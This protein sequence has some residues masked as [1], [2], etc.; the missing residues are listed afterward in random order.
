MLRE[1]SW[2]FWKVQTILRL[3]MWKILRK[4]PGKVEE[5]SRK[6]KI[7]WGKSRKNQDF[8]EKSLQIFWKIYFWK[9]LF[10][11]FHLRWVLAIA[12]VS[13]ALW[14]PEPVCTR[15]IPFIHPS[16]MWFFSKFLHFSSTFL[17]PFLNFSSTENIISVQIATSGIGRV[18]YHHQATTGCDSTDPNVQQSKS[19]KMQEFSKSWISRN[20]QV[21]N[22]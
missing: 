7:I 15:K 9:F 16:K 6:E 21:R 13:A 8:F 2:V 10:K 11:I 3:V 14:G 5:K 12:H 4:D 22:S 18:P 20:L 17:W 1:S 19:K